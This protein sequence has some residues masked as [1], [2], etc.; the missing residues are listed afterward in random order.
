ME[1]MKNQLKDLNLLNRFLFAETMEDPANM[2]DMLDIILGQD[3]VLKYLPQTEKEERTSPV[4][5]FVKLDVCAWDMEDTVYDT[6]VQR[7]NTK[8]LPKRSRLY[9]GI[10]DSKLL[11]PGVV[12]FNSLNNVFIILITPFDLFGHGL[13]RYTFEMQCKEI[14]SL[15]LSDGAV[16]IFLNTRGTD[17][18]GVTNELKELLRYIEH[19]TDE[20]SESCKSERIHNMHE[21]ISKIK[22]S[23]EFGVKFMQEWEE[24][25]IE[26]QKAR[27][28]GLA[29][30][31][32]V[33]L[34][35]QIQK[36]L[37]KGYTPIQ[38]ADALEEE[39]SVIEEMIT[40]IK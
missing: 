38:I 25:I 20:V 22:S 29:E 11:P 8:N 6:E 12:D 2:K 40:R 21:R 18:S 7:E 9:Q 33:L 32:S 15:T 14:P 23:E 28:E 30:G 17:D 36:K 13:Y 34:M 5:R 19:T 4:N 39:L 24:K 1:T 27:E 10:I 16:R 35:E 26:R 31:K 37:K 3:T